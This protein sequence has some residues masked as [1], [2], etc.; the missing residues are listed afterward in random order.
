MTFVPITSLAIQV[1]ASPAAAVVLKDPLPQW[2]VSNLVLCHDLPHSGDYVSLWVPIAIE[3]PDQFHLLVR[4]DKP[5]SGQ[6]D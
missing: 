5:L 2:K 6:H 1:D 3:K 4:I